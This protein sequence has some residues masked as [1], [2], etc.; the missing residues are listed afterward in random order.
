MHSII[1]YNCVSWVFL[2][3][4]LKYTFS[5]FNLFI[6]SFS[7]PSFFLPN[8]LS[9]CLSF[10]LFSFFFYLSFS[11]FFLSFFLSFFQTFFL[12]FF[13]SFLLSVILYSFISFIHLFNLT[14]SVSYSLVLCMCKGLHARPSTIPGVP[15]KTERWIF[16]TLRA[17]S[18]VYFYIIRWSIFR[19]REWCL[20]HSI[21]LSNFDSMAISWNTVIFKFRWIFS[22]DELWIVAG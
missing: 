4:S 12:S 20:D 5:N 22:T 19:R 18:V 10:F 15:E 17:E 16:S 1:Q 14:F 21:W 6:L 3:S 7:I 2:L 13:L 8:F 11:L 9:F